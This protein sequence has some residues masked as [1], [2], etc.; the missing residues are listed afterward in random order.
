MS[1]IFE[2][3]S[4]RTEAC[5]SQV[6]LVRPRIYRCGCTSLSAKT[7]KLGLSFKP[8]HAWRV[9]P[10]SVSRVSSWSEIKNHLEL[11]P[12][13]D[14]T[15]R[16]WPG[17]PVEPVAVPLRTW[18]LTYIQPFQFAFLL[19][20]K[21]YQNTHCF[22]RSGT[23]FLSET[24]GPQP[25][26]FWVPASLQEICLFDTA[27]GLERKVSASPWERWPLH[28]SSGSNSG[29]F[30]PWDLRSQTWSSKKG[31]PARAI[32][33]VRVYPVCVRLIRAWRPEE[34]MLMLEG[35]W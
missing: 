25:T 12:S 6:G 13:R 14:V 31:D 28:W 24:I 22:F 1:T 18:I 3:I 27:V 33:T 11:I 26:K 10:V 8:W 21:S 5:L 9:E 29:R 17:A 34:L 32:G 7:L 20:S 16:D 35:I 30:N 15:Q 23:T 2:Q 4:P 19:I